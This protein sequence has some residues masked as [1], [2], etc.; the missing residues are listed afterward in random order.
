MFPPRQPLPPSPGPGPDVAGRIVPELSRP[1]DGRA[2][3]VVPAWARIKP[4]TV[5]L[6]LCLVVGSKGGMGGA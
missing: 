6:V 5:P 3:T 4:E 2:G 1:F